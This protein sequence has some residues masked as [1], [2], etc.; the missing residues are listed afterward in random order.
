M[1]DPVVDDFN[2]MLS[3]MGIS[4][5]NNTM[6]HTPPMREMIDPTKEIPAM[7]QSIRAGLSSRTE[8]ITSMG[9]DPKVIEDQISKDNKKADSLGLILDSDPRYTTI[10]GK[11]QEVI[12]E[13]NQD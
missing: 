6:T 3:L 7:I 12:N 1:L 13:E 11:K 5:E 4:S 8:T 10:N 2:F 9:R